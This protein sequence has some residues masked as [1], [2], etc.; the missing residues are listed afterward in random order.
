MVWIREA[1]EAGRVQA[2]EEAAREAARAAEKAAFDA[3]PVSERKVAAFLRRHQAPVLP[4]VVDLRKAGYK[5]ERKDPGYVHHSYKREPGSE[6][7]LRRFTLTRVVESPG[8]GMTDYS[9]WEREVFALEWT[10]SRESYYGRADSL[11]WSSI[12]CY[13]SNRMAT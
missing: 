7:D 10:V 2:E 12:S 11:C 3:E 13:C 4:L 8:W 5:V 1:E 9:K 6:E